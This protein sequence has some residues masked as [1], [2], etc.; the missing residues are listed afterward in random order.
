MT[1]NG[2]SNQGAPSP[3]SYHDQA[4]AEPTGPSDGPI[5]GGTRSGAIP[6]SGATDGADSPL[7]PMPIRTPMPMSMSMPM[8]EAPARTA[9]AFPVKP[10]SP[11]TV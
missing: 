11:I 10:S 7:T 9:V 3:W 8:L 2:E 6:P 4:A 1:E 5:F